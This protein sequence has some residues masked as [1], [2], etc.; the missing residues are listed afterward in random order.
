MAFCCCYIF[1]VRT[2]RSTYKTCEWISGYFDDRDYFSYVSF[3]IN[4]SDDRRKWRRE[5]AAFHLNYSYHVHRVRIRFI[6]ICNKTV[7]HQSLINQLKRL[8]CKIG[9]VRLHIRNSI[10]KWFEECRVYTKNKIAYFLCC[11]NSEIQY[12]HKFGSCVK[13]HL[14]FD[15]ISIHDI[16]HIWFFF[17][18]SSNNQYSKPM[19]TMKYF[20][21]KRR[22]N[23]RFTIEANL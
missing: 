8:A 11:S 23:K 22:K 5:E 17:V 9:V 12:I 15:N 19:Y 14:I 6:W 18:N 10:I 16:L 2:H 3:L 20:F 13:F 1:I 4:C 21:Y 7:I